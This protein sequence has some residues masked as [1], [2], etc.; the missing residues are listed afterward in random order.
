MA[1]DNSA[2]S[3]LTLALD[4]ASRAPS[5]ALARPEVIIASSSLATTDHISERL[6]SEIDLLMEEAV[7]GIDDVEL[8]AV[9][10]GPGGFTGLRVGVAAIKGFALATSRPAIG[11]TALEAAALA[12]DSRGLVCSMVGAYKNE[13]YSQLFSFDK[14]GAPVAENQPAVTTIAEAVDRM[15]SIDSVVFAGD[16][17][18]DHLEAIR[19]ARPS[20]WTARDETRYLSEA[21]ARLAIMRYYR[22]EAQDAESV[23][24]FYVRRAEAEIKLS[25][26]LLGSKIKR[27]IRNE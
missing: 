26:G 5:I 27:S 22:G 19:Q 3:P 10:A 15:A 11:V 4:T 21:I 1:I 2:Q 8:F 6:W 9:C 17:V 12:A 18:A 25:L 13:V 16:A 7:I 24:A 14:E 23:Q 20:G